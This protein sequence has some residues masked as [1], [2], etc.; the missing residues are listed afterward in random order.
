MSFLWK[1][2]HLILGSSGKRDFGKHLLGPA[3]AQLT[4]GLL[5]QG[6]H[7]LRHKVAYPT[8]ISLEATV[9]KLPERLRANSKQQ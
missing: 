5:K 4:A 2:H 8:G 3:G 9:L 7:C 6:L 1:D